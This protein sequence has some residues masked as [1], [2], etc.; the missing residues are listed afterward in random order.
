MGE[1][2]ASKVLGD[3]SLKRAIA[4]FEKKFKDKTGHKWVDR[5]EDPKSGKYTFLERNYEPDSEDEDDDHG[6][7]RGSKTSDG[8]EKAVRKQAECTLEQ[9][10][11]DL[12]RLIFNQAFFTATMAD[13]SYDAQK[14]PLGKL[15]KRTLESGFKALKE[16]AELQIDHSLASSKHGKTFAQAVEDLSNRYYTVIPHSF[17]RSRPPIIADDQ[18]L[19]KEIELL[20]SLSEMSIAD[21]IMKE[22]KE[23]DGDIVHPLDH[24]F[25]GLNLSEMVPRE[26]LL[27]ARFLSF[28]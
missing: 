17:G 18:R 10:V 15:S 11:Q 23:E 24:Q 20:D 12:L 19:K 3:G 6:A 2:G 28:V 14:L 9:P 8:N 16:L 13:M 1:F 25:K 4:E 26:F 22:S 27:F 21:E 7:R 5:L